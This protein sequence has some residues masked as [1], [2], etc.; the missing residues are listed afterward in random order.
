M[1][2]LFA[3]L[4]V[5]SPLLAVNGSE[6]GKRDSSLTPCDVQWDRGRRAPA[7]ECYTALLQ[8]SDPA[9]RAEAWW[10]LGDVKQ[11]N[12]VFRSA[13]DADQENPDL[14]VRWGYLYVQTHQES[15]AMKLFTEALE[16][17][18]DHMAAKL[19]TASVMG[20]RF[21]EKA[22]GIID[23]AI[24]E[25][26]E[27]ALAYRMKARLL[28]EQGDLD[29]AEKSL[30]I[31]LEK[32]E[33]LGRSPL[34]TYA[35]LASVDMQRGMMESPWTKKALEHNPRYGKLFE[36]A[37][38]FFVIT[39]R[40]REAVE[41]YEKAVEVDPALWSAHADLG[42]N[43]MRENREEE[44]IRHLKIAYEGDPFSAQTVNSLR[45][46]DSFDNFR[47]YSNKDVLR[48]GAPALPGRSGD[49]R[50]AAQEGSGPAEALRD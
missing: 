39:R 20:R 24:D 45:L 49:P 26:P 23:E 40:Y 8:S 21:E 28:L 9:I 1:R 44:G 4:L 50:P 33:T 2:L 25:E 6:R 43:L 7:R 36:E 3:A 31:A 37:A 22:N 14:R 5:V 19:G 42:V 38:H 17:D 47:T 10:A 12:D 34:E 29:E 46:A 32:G 13:V 30:Q 15:E 48:S 41:L 18:E 27:Q 35:L 16:I 11:A